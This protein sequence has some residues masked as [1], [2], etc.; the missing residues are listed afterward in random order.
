[1]AHHF[2]NTTLWF[3][4]LFPAIVPFALLFIVV[5]INLLLKLFYRDF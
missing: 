1:M 4:A 2:D 3:L 5:V